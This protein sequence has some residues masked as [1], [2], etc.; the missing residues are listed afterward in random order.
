MVLRDVVERLESKAPFSVMMRALLENVL[1][2][3]R[4]DAIF[5]AND[6]MALSALQVIHQ[7]GLRIPED[8]GVIGFDKGQG[9]RYLA[10]P[11]SVKRFE[12]QRIVG[13]DWS[14]VPS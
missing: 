7:K 12:G 10:F 13:I 9:A 6:Q 8:I 1:S 11:K 4:M 3:E 14:L 2:D 5:V